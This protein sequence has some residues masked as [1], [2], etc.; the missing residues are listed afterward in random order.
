M[1]ILVQISQSATATWGRS[2]VHKEDMLVEYWQTREYLWKLEETWGQVNGIN[3]SWISWIVLLLHTLERERESERFLEAT[4]NFQIRAGKPFTKNGGFL[5]ENTISKFRAHLLFLLWEGGKNFE[6][7]IL[8]SIKKYWQ[9]QHNGEWLL[10][11]ADLDML[12]LLLHAFAFAF[13]S[14]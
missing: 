2:W 8:I 1:S 6:A 5:K 14:P 4:H 11:S 10:D 9:S 13:A 3:S 12:L 7:I